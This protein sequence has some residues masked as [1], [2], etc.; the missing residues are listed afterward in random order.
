MK[1]KMWKLMIAALAVLPVALVSCSDELIPGITGR[2]EIV[3]QNMNVDDMTGFVTTI[4][5]EVY[6]SQGTQQE[7]RVVA[8]Q[9]IIDN[10]DFD[11]VTDGIWTIHYRDNV[12]NAKP[13]KIYITLPTLTLAGISGSGEIK[14][15]TPFTGLEDLSLVVSGSG[16]MDLETESQ[17]LDA[18]ISGSGDLV[19]SGKTGQVTLVVSGSG[20]F[21]GTDLV[22]P[23]AEMT[24]SGSG[25][26]RLTVE[27]HLH[28]LV[29]GSGNVYYLGNPELDV[30]VSGSGSV[31]R[32]R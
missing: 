29:S 30:H 14:G 18:A 19:I 4:S 17:K 1:T 27:E 2:G 22:T 3:E 9:N 28:A 24:I 32:L 8:Q 16:S 20:G 5:A 13:V 15:L 7:V 11:P 23:Q 26:A 21:H 6:I 12:W 25:S 31:N 10:I